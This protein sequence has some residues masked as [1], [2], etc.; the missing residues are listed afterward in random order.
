[1]GSPCCLF[2]AG[3]TPPAPGHRVEMSPG[4]TLPL[5]LPPSVVTFQLTSLR[6]G[7]IS[8]SHH[9]TCPLQAPSPAFDLRRWGEVSARP[10]K[11]ESP[12]NRRPCRVGTGQS[13]A[14]WPGG[15][16]AHLE[17]ISGEAVTGLL[18]ADKIC[19]GNPPGVF[20]NLADFL[21]RHPEGPGW[22]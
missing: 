15:R 7:E 17:T 6:E 12:V 20:R 16:R 1:M 4:G 19:W 18:D 11:S 14:C 3:G 10:Q 2:P 8:F 21:G 13:G 9:G 5:M 22:H